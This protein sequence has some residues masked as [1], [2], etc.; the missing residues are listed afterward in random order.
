[1]EDLGSYDLLRDKLNTA[2]LDLTVLDTMSTNIAK[3]HRSTHKATLTKEQHQEL[4]QL[5]E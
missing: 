2:D 4:L 3:L 1:M 5:S